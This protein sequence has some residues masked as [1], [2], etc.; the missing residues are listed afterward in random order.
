VIDF[1]HSTTLAWSSISH[2]HILPAILFASSVLSAI[3]VAVFVA[4]AASSTLSE[5]FL[6]ASLE[7]LESLLVTTP[8]TP[9]NAVQ[10]AISHG[11][12]SRFHWLQ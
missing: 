10:R 12:T 2:C 6:I 1:T 5:A 4:L 8:P 11:V 9:P 3:S 7:A